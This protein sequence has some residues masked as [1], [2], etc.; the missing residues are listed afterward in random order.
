MPVCW[1]TAPTTSPPGRRRGRSG[2]A[3][4]GRPPGAARLRRVLGQLQLVADPRS[5][6]TA[7][8]GASSGRGGAGRDLE[9]MVAV[10][11]LLEPEAGQLLA[12]LEPLPRPADTHDTPSGGQRRADAL[13]ELAG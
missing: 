11:G 2:A 13:A 5:S 3:G 9:G 1:P 10:E 12:A 8:S 4:G 7:A 6:T